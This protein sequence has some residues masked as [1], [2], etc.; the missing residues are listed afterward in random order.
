MSAIQGEVS[1]ISFNGRPFSVDAEADISGIL[2]AFE[3]ELKADG[4]CTVK[5]IK[6]GYF[7]VSGECDFFPVIKPRRNGKP[8]SR[9]LLKK[10]S[11]KQWGVLEKIC[12]KHGNQWK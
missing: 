2:Q 7:E 6:P 9:R 10:K 3:N 11:N 4:N 1:E 8:W 12:R 5:L